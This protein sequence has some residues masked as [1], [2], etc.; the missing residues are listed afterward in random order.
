MAEPPRG[1]SSWEPLLDGAA[2]L[3]LQLHARGYAPA[4]IAALTERH[5]VDVVQDLL[6]AARLLGVGTVPEAV[7][8]ARRRGLIV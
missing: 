6:R 1:R 7:D 3:A 5:A 2:L 4:Q 8:E